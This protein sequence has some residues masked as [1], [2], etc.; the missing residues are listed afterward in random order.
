MTPPDQQPSHPGHA[1]AQLTFSFGVTSFQLTPFFRLGSLDLKALSDVVSLHLVA[2]R[3]AEDPL[4]AGISFQIDRVEL[5]GTR[6]RSLVLRPLGDA[7][8]VAAPLPNL[9]VDGVA[10]TNTGDA[11]ITVTTG[12]GGATAVQLVG[13]FAVAGIDFSPAFEVETLRLEPTAQTALLRVVPS[14]RPT[15]LDLPPSFDFAE[16][17]LGE[18]G[19]LDAVRLVPSA[20]PAA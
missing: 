12:G 17:R 10:V 5:D 14:E 9:Q 6:L 16:V 18:G 1:L 2:A 4:A 20:A 3:S 13:T 11:P 15:A 19:Q 8:P 7:R